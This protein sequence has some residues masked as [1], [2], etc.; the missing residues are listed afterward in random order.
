MST[1]NLSGTDIAC[2]LARKK[3]DDTIL[4]GHILKT[5]EKPQK[6]DEFIRVPFWNQKDRSYKIKEID[7]KPHVHKDYEQ[8]VAQCEDLGVVQTEVPQNNLI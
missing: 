6:G 7:Y 4:S 3:G 2:C 5:A 8:W 1:F